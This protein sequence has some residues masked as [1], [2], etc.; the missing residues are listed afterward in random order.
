MTA[1]LNRLSW[2]LAILMLSAMFAL[3]LAAQTEGI[4]LLAH[5]GS[6]TWNEEVLNLATR[7]DQITPVEVA[8]G[9]AS[10]RTIQAAVDRLSERG[11]GRDRSCS[12]VHFLPQLDHPCDGVSVGGA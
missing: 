6:G 7:L 3:P 10:K 1:T 9:M 11:G 5:G 12:T 4:L 2:A 8:F